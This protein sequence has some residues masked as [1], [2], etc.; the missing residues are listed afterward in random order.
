MFQACAQAWHG[1]KAG[2]RKELNG[3]LMAKCR[4]KEGVKRRCRR[5]G[6]NSSSQVGQSVASFLPSCYLE[7][8]CKG[9]HCSHHLE[10]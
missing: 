8:E 6:S 5:G 9:W 4:G 10:S 2:P 1:D 7:W 3:G